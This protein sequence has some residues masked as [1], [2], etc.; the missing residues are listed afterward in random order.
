MDQLERAEVS[1]SG[2]GVGPSVW[3]GHPR[4]AQPKADHPRLVGLVPEPRSM[5]WGRCHV[6]QRVRGRVVTDFVV[7]CLG[8]T[9]TSSG[10][11]IPAG[12]PD[13]VNTKWPNLFDRITQTGAFDQFGEQVG[14]PRG[15]NHVSRLGLAEWG[16]WA[17]PS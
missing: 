16:R 11:L 17:R 14:V 1:R 13:F 9:V 6:N 15:P 5:Y 7:Y 12:V 8:G 4:W 2:L 3:E 10:A